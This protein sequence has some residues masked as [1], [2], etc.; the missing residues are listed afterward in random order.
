MGIKLLRYTPTVLWFVGILVASFM[1]SSHISVK[2]YLFPHQDKLIHACMYF[3]LAFLFLCNSRHF[4]QLSLA[5]ISISVAIICTLSGIIE[6]L[7][8]ILSNRTNDVLD[9][10]ANGTGAILAGAIVFALRKRL[11]LVNV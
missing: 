5:F 8:P 1:S 3:G 6:I 11:V 9:F 2:L 4:F 7:Q 10:V